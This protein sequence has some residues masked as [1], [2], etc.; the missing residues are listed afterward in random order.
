MAPRDSG[1]IIEESGR[2]PVAEDLALFHMTPGGEPMT[3]DDRCLRLEE[4]VIKQSM[5]IERLKEH[6]ETMEAWVD[7]AAKIGFTVGVGLL[8][9]IGFVM[10]A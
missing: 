6:Q 3:P 1:P 8:L 2:G 5:E 7:I 10:F 4:I 9:V